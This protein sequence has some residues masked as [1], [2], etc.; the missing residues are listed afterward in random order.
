MVIYKKDINL[1]ASSIKINKGI[2]LKIKFSQLKLYSQRNQYKK[3]DSE[4]NAVNN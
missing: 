2:L 4:R 1:D 3:K